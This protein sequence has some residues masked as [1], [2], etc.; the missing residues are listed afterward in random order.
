MKWFLV[1]WKHFFLFFTLMYSDIFCETWLLWCLGWYSLVALHLSSPEE[2]ALDSPIRKGFLFLL[3]GEFYHPNSHFSVFNMWSF[4]RGFH[5]VRNC[6]HYYFKELFLVW[7]NDFSLFFFVLVCA[8]IDRSFLFNSL[9][10]FML[11]LHLGF[12]FWYILLIFNKMKDF[13][14]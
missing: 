8:I 14:R 10:H 4:I 6:I 2:D 13:N 11:I 1:A 7:C 3:K 5:Y 12:D 9:N